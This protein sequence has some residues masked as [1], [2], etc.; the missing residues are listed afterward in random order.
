MIKSI[1]DLDLKGKRVFFRFDFNVPLDQSGAIKDDTRIRRALPTIEYA[2]E[3]GAKCIFTSH[4]GRPKGERKAEMS[5]APVAGRLQE[6]LGTAVGFADDCIGAQAETAVANLKDGDAVLL[7]NLRFHPGETKNDPDFASQL[8]SLAD[9]YVNDA[10]GTAH[11]AH[12]STVGVPDLLKEKAAGFLM[13]EELENLEKA[14]KNPQKPVVALFGGAKVSDKT[15]LLK[16]LVNRM[17]T[18][19]I[20]GGMANT[21]LKAQGSDV[22]ASKTEEEMVNTA[23][24][25][26]R[27]KK[28]TILLPVDV[29]VADRM[30]DGASTRTVTSDFIPSGQMALDIGPKTVQDFSDEISRAGTIVWNGPMGVFEI[31]AFK[32]GTMKIAEAVASA[33]A[34]SLI[35]GGDTIRAIQQAGVADKI[36]YISTGGGA[37][38]EFMEGKILPGVAALE[39]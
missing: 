29:V 38:M 32:N 33:S 19:L 21:F 24:E 4:L 28:C 13:K 10:F 16:N 27:D 5:L 12:A 15:E 18:I 11:R 20:G 8:A 25:I 17:D 26:L 22:G 3:H 7:E 37:F 14:L 1:K 6:L 2:M 39:Q 31:D 35:G 30:E 34:F 9:V 36:S 23:A